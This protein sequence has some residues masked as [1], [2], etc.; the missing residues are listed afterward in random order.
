MRSRGPAAP[1]RAGAVRLA[2]GLALACAAFT[3][4]LASAGIGRATRDR[5]PP[6]HTGGFGEPTCQTCHFDR[7]TNAGPGKLRIDGIPQTFEPGREYTLAIELRSPDLR[8][9]GFQIAA[10]FQDGTQ[11]GTLAPA[12]GDEGRVDSTVQNHIL[13]AHHSLAGTEPHEDDVVR[14]TL[15]WTAPTRTGTVLFHA[16]ANAA[17]GDDSPLGD[18]IYADS[19]ASSGTRP[20]AVGEAAGTGRTGHR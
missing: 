3:M 11:A 13:F 4:I 1:A 15:V 14:W 18:L 8:A 16:A 19:A 9:A 17:N 7:E 6:G 12:P 20:G 10:R 2:R 5:P